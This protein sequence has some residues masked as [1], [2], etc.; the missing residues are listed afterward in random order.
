MSAAHGAEERAQGDAISVRRLAPCARAPVCDRRSRAARLVH[1]CADWR[2][3][4][5]GIGARVP[6]IIRWPSFFARDW[7][8]RICRSFFSDMAS[9]LVKVR[10]SRPS[11][12][13]AC[14][15]KGGRSRRMACRGF[16]SAFSSISFS[17]S[18]NAK[19][20]KRYRSWALRDG[21]LRLVE[22]DPRALR[23]SD[24]ARSGKWIR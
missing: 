22:D 16:L 17:P 8:R 2:P 19:P 6:W 11:C 7:Y 13:R 21:G 5:A 9:S 10:S 18:R 1:A 23:L 3:S 14:G 15:A 20:S 4:H 12:R 24:G